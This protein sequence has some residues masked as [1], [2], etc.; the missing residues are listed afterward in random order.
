LLAVIGFFVADELRD[1]HG[2]VAE[3]RLGQVIHGVSHVRL[4]PTP[5]TRS[6][7]NSLS[8]LRAWA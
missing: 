5:S 4:G 8:I 1:R 2:R 7:R 3:I 6:G